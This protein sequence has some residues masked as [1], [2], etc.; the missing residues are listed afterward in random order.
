VRLENLRIE[1]ITALIRFEVVAVKK[2][3]AQAS[4]IAASP[5]THYQ[6]SSMSQLLSW[7]VFRS[8]SG[9]RGLGLSV[10]RVVCLIVRRC[11]LE[12]GGFKLGLA[13]QALNPTLS[14][15]ERDQF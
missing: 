9:K 15:P 3:F 4:Q 11:L 10:A 1:V 8:P 6:A 13:A 7:C 12:L 5:R 2:S 14:Q